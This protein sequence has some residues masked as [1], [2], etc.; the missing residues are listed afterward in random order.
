MSNPYLP[1]EILDCVVDLLYD[2]PNTLKGCCLVSKSWIPR[3]RKH[4]FASVPFYVK[5]NLESW[6]KTFPDPSTSPAHYTKSLRVGCPYVVTAADADADA[7]GWIRGFSRV[8]ELELDA[9]N[10]RTDQPRISLVPFHGFSP[11]I[12]SLSMTFSTLP[13]SRTVNLIL[14]FPL[15]EDLTLRGIGPSI[16]EGDSPDG[17]PTAIQPQ[18][19]PAFCGSLE[20]PLNDWTAPI[21]RQFLSIASGGIHFRRLVLTW[22]HKK[23]LSLA[24]A[25]VGECSDTLESL[26]ITRCLTGKHV[27]LAFTP[28]SMTYF[29]FQ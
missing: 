3:T 5:A 17:P 16:D 1:P 28:A 18:N 27:Y 4:L 13:P 29:R 8:V 7:G 20:L 2:D 19:L 25:L 15:L 9:C 10:A 14:S 21:A 23:E 24:M 6:K 11:A 22:R 12:K 26:D